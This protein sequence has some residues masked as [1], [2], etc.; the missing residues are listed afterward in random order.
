MPSGETVGTKVDNAIDSTNAAIERAG[1]S[2]GEAA[3]SGE[4]AAKDVAQKIEKTGEQVGSVIA[5]SVI[6]AA[7]K[8]DLIKDPAIRAFKIDVNTVDGE[9]TLRG[10]VSSRAARESAERLAAGTKGVVKVDNQLRIAP[11]A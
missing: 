5:D 8:A 3:R 6:T 7:V 9:V 4:R 2:A 1:D 11:N 10:E